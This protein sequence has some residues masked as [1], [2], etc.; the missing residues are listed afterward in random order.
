MPQVTKIEPQKKNTNRFN[1]FIDEKFAFGISAQNL[2][3]KSLK[4]GK[5]LTAADIEKIAKY[6]NL[7]KLQDIAMHYLNFRPRS[8]KELKNH[9]A[10]KLALK[11]NINFSQA[12]HS[13]LVQTAINKLK[14][15]KFINDLEF[16]K[17]FVSSRQTNHIKSS[18]LIAQELKFRGVDEEIIKKALSKI[19]DEKVLAIRTLQKKVKRWANLPES[20]RKKKIYQFLLFKGFSYDIAKEAFAFFEKKD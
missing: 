14:K 1:V 16:A 12:Q 10:K 9:L 13:P 19:V 17:W 18:K 20:E 2:L 7:S 5:I 11:E 6:E 3:E 8:E 15:Y 4:V